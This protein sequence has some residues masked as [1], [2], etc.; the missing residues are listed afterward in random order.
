MG[1]FQYKQEIQVVGIS[2]KRMFKAM[3]IEFHTLLPK[4]KPDVVSRIELISG[5]GG[6]G[7]TRKT[8]LHNHVVA[9]ILVLP[10]TSFLKHE[11]SAV[12]A[13][14][15]TAKYSLIEGAWLGEKLE[16]VDYDVKFEESSNGGCVIKITSDY[17]TKGDAVFDDKDSKA[18]NDRAREYYTATEEYL[19]LNPDV[20]A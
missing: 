17:R 1:A 4:I 8:H 20:C 18:D 2:P 7:T 5:D 15:C 16:R 10:S 9:M 12:N 3:V 13:E 14:M 11:T 6:P 19:R